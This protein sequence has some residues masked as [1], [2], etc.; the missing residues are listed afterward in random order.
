MATYTLRDGMTLTYSVNSSEWQEITFAAGDF[1][2]INAA[3]GEEIAAVINNSADLRAST[4]A[5]GSLVIHTASTG[6]HVTLAVLPTPGGAH[7]PL[8]LTGQDIRA[9]GSGLVAAQLT[10]KPAPF[11]VPADAELTLNMDG[12]NRRV[13]FPD[14]ASTAA[15]V[16][17][18]FNDK[19]DGIALVTHDQRVLLTSPTIGAGSVLE[20]SPGRGTRPDASE[21]LGLQN[22]RSHPYPLSAASLNCPG[23]GVLMQV[24][25]TSP[26]PVEIHLPTRSLVLQ[27]QGALTITPA[28]ATAEP[29]QRLVQ[30]G[31]IRVAP[32]R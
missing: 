18:V 31:V 13:R 32:N 30:Q 29:L 8:G 17:A 3:T 21:P 4:T 14:G 15:E 1:E 26:R 6:G 19:I 11:E 20:A 24:I 16:A 23:D 2:D 5:N 28:E 9:S 27:G 7:A 10:T 12:Q 25:N 22:A